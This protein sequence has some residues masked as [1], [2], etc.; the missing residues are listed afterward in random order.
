MK[1]HKKC[2]INKDFD[3][4][5]TLL[6]LSFFYLFNKT[7]LN[8]IVQFLTLKFFANRFELKTLLN[9]KFD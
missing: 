6:F 9:E 3:V 5:E 1:K 7:K 8:F 2:K 4:D